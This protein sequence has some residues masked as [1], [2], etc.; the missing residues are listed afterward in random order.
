MLEELQ[1]RQV[2]KLSD[3][4]INWI[5]SLHVALFGWRGRGVILGAKE[6]HELRD[7]VVAQRIAKGRH[8]LSAVQDLVGHLVGWPVLVAANVG[9][10]RRLLRS[11]QIGAMTVGAALVAEEHSAGFDVGWRVGCEGNGG[12]KNQYGREEF[13]TRFHLSIFA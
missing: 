2:I 1:C 3:Y 6:C 10:G 8:L 9:E 7:L 13:D 12:G 11:V 4:L 5:I